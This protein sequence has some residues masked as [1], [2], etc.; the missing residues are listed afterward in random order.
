M[1]GID[2]DKIEVN[3][4]YSRP[5]NRNNGI[6]LNHAKKVPIPNK[7]CTVE[8]YTKQTANKHHGR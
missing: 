5:N 7:Y 8:L 1:A 3:A 2:A 6:I 4:V